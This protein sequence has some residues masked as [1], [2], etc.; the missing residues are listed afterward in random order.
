MRCV[1]VDHPWEMAADREQ[2]LS[3]VATWKASGRSA[4]DFARGQGY[5]SS[6][7][8]YWSCR[9]RKEA[10]QNAENPETEAPKPV[11]LARVLRRASEPRVAF[12]SSDASL[13][14]NSPIAIVIGGMSVVVQ[15]GFDARTLS[16]VVDVL[17]SRARSHAGAR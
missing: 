6:A 2:W 16:S 4:K 13:S 17:E 7:L 1:L 11:R 9:L 5:S 14:A 15:S 3:R 8:Q 12:T 10:R